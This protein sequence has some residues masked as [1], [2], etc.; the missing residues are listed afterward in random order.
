MKKILVVLILACVALCSCSRN[1]KIVFDSSDS[2]ALAM[3]VNWAVV[4]DPYVAFR[5]EPGYEND[6]KEHGRMGD[7][8]MV[9]GK[10]Y[11][12]QD[13]ENVFWY[14]FDQGWLE[15]NSIRVYD[16]KLKAET[17]SKELLK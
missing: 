2:L 14:N 5:S 15:E 9:R 17:A 3:D 6:V 4:S 11:Y 16:N 13:G 8:L 12:K 7:I 1:E 10:R